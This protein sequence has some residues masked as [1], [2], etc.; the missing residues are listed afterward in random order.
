M[1]PV[2]RPAALIASLSVLSVLAACTPP[3][4]AGEVQQ[5]LAGAEDPAADFAVLAVTRETL[6]I[7]ATWP[8]MPGGTAT[9]GW[10][11]RGGGSK[12]DIVAPGDAFDVTMFSNEENGLLTA[13][14]QK[15]TPLAGLKVAADGTVF[16]PYAGTVT[17][18][19]L[20]E[21][22]ARLAIQDKLATIMPSAQVLLAYQPGRENSVQVVSGLPVSG[23]V[24]LPDHDYTVLDLI[25]ESGGV[26]AE[27][28][29]PQV[30][31]AR[32]G[33]LYGT[34][35]DNLVQNPALDAVL[36]PGDRIY[37]QPEDRYFMSFGAA[38][39]ETQINFPRAEVSALDA[40]T[41]IG[42]LND[43]IADPKGV[44]ILRNYPA[45]AV[46]ADGTGPS[47]DR[48]IFMFDLMSADG[49]FSAG[50]FRIENQDLVMVAQAPLVNQA[51]VVDYLSTLLAVPARASAAVAAVRAF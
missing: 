11:P 7:V 34:G 32:G 48:M 30:Q 51:A 2:F 5:V 25:A 14:G 33:K 31:V 16:L 21:D 17:V 18:A 23:V 47:K 8:G 37:L 1:A 3:Q 38:S 19:G 4:G 45:S 15:I 39:D 28:I 50:K 44:L 35:F 42:G 20:S 36:R 27:M 9:A 46:R 26:P 6:P 29:N 13:P 22:Q 10:L 41:L 40:V 24:S 12:R 49:L 43:S